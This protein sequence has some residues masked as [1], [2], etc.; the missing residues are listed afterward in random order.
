M[1]KYNIWAAESDEMGS[2]SSN[3]GGFEYLLCVIDVFTKY[4]LVKPSKDKKSKRAFHVFIEI[5]NESKRKPNK[6]SVDQ[7][8]EFC[9]RLMQKLLDGNEIFNT[10]E[11]YWR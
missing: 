3:N 5:V 11:S 10:I 4:A 8:E 6:L 2:I 1:F 9:N 7:G